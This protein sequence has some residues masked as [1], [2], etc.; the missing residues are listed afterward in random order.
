MKKEAATK[1][2]DAGLAWASLGAFIGKLSELTI[3]CST[4]LTHVSSQD[5]SETKDKKSA[6]L[7]AVI[8]INTQGAQKLQEIALVLANKI[9]EQHS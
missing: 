4:A 8:S 6:I 5:E 3:Y 1:A 9:R 7:I 2:S